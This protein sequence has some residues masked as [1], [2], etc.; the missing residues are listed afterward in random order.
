MHDKFLQRRGLS[1][2]IFNSRNSSRRA[3]VKVHRGVRHVDSSSTPIKRNRP[4]GSCRT[5]ARASACSFETC[6]KIQTRTARPSKGKE[7]YT[8]TR[9]GGGNRGS[10]GKYTV[11]GY[12]CRSRCNIYTARV[13]PHADE[14]SS[15]YIPHWTLDDNA[16]ARDNEIRSA[17]ECP[18][19]ITA[20]DDANCA[21]LFATRDARGRKEA[22]KK[23]R[24][25]SVS[26]WPG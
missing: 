4:C 10:R 3:D 5:R 24:R 15:C 19:L 16:A 1:S 20:R 17:C 22:Q 18:A 11:L 2:A 14:R 6:L 25:R 21:L 9:R 7:K 12:F 26:A 13:A 23:K 8:D